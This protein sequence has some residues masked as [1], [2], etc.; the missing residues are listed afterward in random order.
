MVIAAGVRLPGGLFGDGVVR[1]N[2][3]NGTAIDAPDGVAAGTDILSG[4]SVEIANGE[5]AL[6]GLLTPDHPVALLEIR[7]G[8]GGTG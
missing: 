8:T 2:P 4:R 1:A 7:S 3:W 6:D 5:I